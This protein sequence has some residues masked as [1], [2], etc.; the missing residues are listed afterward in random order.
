MENK[1]NY[2]Y[3]PEAQEMINTINKRDLFRKPDQGSDMIL[4]S[5]DQKTDAKGRAIHGLIAADL[6]STV[7]VNNP[8]DAVLMPAAAI[9]CLCRAFGVATTDENK[10]YVSAAILGVAAEI[11]RAYNGGEKFDLEKSPLL[12]HAAAEIDKYAREYFKKVN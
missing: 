9:V 1:K 11:L 5:L 7:A 8:L 6:T 2:E 3:S 10:K 4:I 12:N